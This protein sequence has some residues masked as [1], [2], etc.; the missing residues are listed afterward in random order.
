MEI[1]VS[2]ALEQ[3]LISKLSLSMSNQSLV[4]NDIKVLVL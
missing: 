3:D 2:T 1:G 4:L